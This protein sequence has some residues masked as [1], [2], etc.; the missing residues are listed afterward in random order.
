MFNVLDRNNIG[1]A[2]LTMNA[3]LGIDSRQF[4]LAQVRLGCGEIGDS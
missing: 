4:G 1:F 2:A 3:D